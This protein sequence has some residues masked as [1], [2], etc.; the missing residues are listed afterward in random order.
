MTWTIDYILPRAHII[1]KEK[2]T[3]WVQSKEREQEIKRW[4]ILIID[5]LCNFF[6]GWFFKHTNLHN[7]GSILVYMKFKAKRKRR[8]MKKRTL[9]EQILGT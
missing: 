3:F 5:V 2:I 6:E 8:E 9:N 4:D 1:Q 7:T